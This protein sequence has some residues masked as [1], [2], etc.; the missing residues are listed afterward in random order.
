MGTT[1]IDVWSFGHLIGGV[2]GRLTIFPN[3]NVLSF[4]ITFIL[5]V[6]VEVIE[7]E[8]NPNTNKIIENKIN[9]FTDIIY[10][11]IGWIIADIYYED[12]KLHGIYYYFYLFIFLLGTLLIILREICPYND[13]L[14][15][16]YIY[17]Q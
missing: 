10:Y 6:I 1:I 11:I 16:T 2:L 12:L 5:H 8:I 14:W 15:G 3:N 7:H 4:I 17:N 13:F 9:K